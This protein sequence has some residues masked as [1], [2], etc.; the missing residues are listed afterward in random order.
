MKTII[1][2]KCDSVVE[3]FLKKVLDE[4]WETMKSFGQV[5]DAMDAEKDSGEL[6]NIKHQAY[7]EAYAQSKR[8]VKTIM[9]VMH[10]Y[11]SN[12]NL[13]DED[14]AKMNDIGYNFKFIKDKKGMYIN[15]SND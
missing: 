6:T 9:Q 2:D 14:I 1:M 5:I 3:A 8:S 11:L 13:D 15:L 7:F 10:K 4:A 12:F